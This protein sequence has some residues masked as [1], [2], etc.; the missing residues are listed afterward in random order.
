[1]KKAVASSILVAVVLLAP[2]A[3]AQQAGKIFRI[4]FLEPLVIMHRIRDQQPMN[5]LRD[6]IKGL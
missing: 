3:E 6:F 1:M 2:I 5:T 4:G